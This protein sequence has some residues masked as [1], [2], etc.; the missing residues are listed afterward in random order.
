MTALMAAAVQ[1]APA[2]QASETVN[3]NE[4][5]L[6][7]Q[8][9]IFRSV[10]DLQRSTGGVPSVGPKNRAKQKNFRNKGTDL[11]SGIAL[12]SGTH[13]TEGTFTEPVWRL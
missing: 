3:I 4:N 12:F 10:N 5:I 13:I 8:M 7:E 2:A 6:T 11:F 9:K 1:S